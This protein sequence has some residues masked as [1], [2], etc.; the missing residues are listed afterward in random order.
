VRMGPRVLRTETA[1]VAAIS[2]LQALV[3]DLS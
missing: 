3:G 2:A 1:A